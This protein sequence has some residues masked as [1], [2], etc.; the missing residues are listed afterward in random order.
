M[1]TAAVGRGT[2]AATARRPDETPPR[3]WLTP[4]SQELTADLQRL[5]AEYVNYK[6]RVDRDRDLVAQN[7]KFAVLGA[8]CPCS[9]TSTGRGSTA[10]STAVS[11]PSRSRSSGSWP[12]HG[13]EKFGAKATSSTRGSTRR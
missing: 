4:A 5:Q 10:S 8:C 13:L 7:A 1:P 12:A 11:R 2:A 6:R 3:R 9:T